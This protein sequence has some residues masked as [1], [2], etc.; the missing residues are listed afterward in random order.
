ML[1]LA[2]E[3]V[4]MDAWLE[5]AEDFLDPWLEQAVI[6]S[7]TIEYIDAQ[8]DSVS[9][10]YLMHAQNASLRFS[11]GY[12]KSSK[13]GTQLTLAML[14]GM[15]LSIAERRAGAL[16]MCVGKHTQNCTRVMSGS[17]NSPRGLPPERDN[18]RKGCARHTVKAAKATKKGCKKALRIGVVFVLW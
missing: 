2:R 6:M 7:Q 1:F 9:K 12:S 8:C 17:P 11:L 18:A 10:G 16:S 13:T 5:D 14:E 3:R 15:A 4:A